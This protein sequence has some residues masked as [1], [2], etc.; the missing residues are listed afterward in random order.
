M[1]PV[2]IRRD[3]A[4]SRISYRLSRLWMRRGVQRAT[5]V[6]LP[7]CAVVVGVAGVALHPTNR[8]MITDTYAEL[9]NDFVTHPRFMVNDVGINGA[10]TAVELLIQDKVTAVLPVS[11]LTLDLADLRERIEA[12]PAVRSASLSIGDANRLM[13]DV[14]QRRPVALWRNRDGL[15]LVDADG[16]AIGFVEAR[17]MRPDLPLIIG[18]GAAREVDEA[19]DILDAAR[20]L[21]PS[22]RGLVR[23]GER[24]WDLVLG[25]DRRI[26]L[27]EANPAEAVLR[28][29]ALN[30]SDDLLARDVALVDLRDTDRPIVRL[31]LDAIPQMRRLRAMTPEEDA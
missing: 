1:R 3:P 26:L 17:Y 11:A 14:D 7:I 27:P 31:G 13:I 6:W 2:K 15:S 4:P 23:M 8:A 30:R 21:A 20:A 19:R 5:R 24:R 16:V 28:L 10:V 22:V 18:R 12:V 25:P 29:M 9:R